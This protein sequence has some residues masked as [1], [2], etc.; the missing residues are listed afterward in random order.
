MKHLI[1]TSDIGDVNDWRDI[2]EDADCTTD[3]E[4]EDYL[5]DSGE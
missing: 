1:W 5:K 4:L 2:L 3:E